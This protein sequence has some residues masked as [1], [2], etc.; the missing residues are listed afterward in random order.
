MEIINCGVLP[1]KLFEIIELKQAFK[2]LTKTS[3][4]QKKLIH[5]I[6][7]IFKNFIHK[8]NIALYTSQ[9]IL[10]KHWVFTYTCTSSINVIHI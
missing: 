8:I 3:N 9:E 10:H 2:N 5:R 4:P 1:H 6:Y 7:M